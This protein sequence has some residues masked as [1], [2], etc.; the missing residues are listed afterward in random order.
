ME[1]EV[2]E[3]AWV[4][5]NLYG[6]IYRSHSMQMDYQKQS[7]EAE[8]SRV[9][10]GRGGHL[11]LLRGLLRDWAGVRLV[12]DR[13]SMATCSRQEE[14]TVLSAWDPLKTFEKRLTQSKGI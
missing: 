2:S 7:K 14:K 6:C 5:G 10:W 1:L 13:K 9:C 3:L 8:K 4:I 12:K 11:A